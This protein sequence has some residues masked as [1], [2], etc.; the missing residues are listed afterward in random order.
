MATQII[1]CP[2]GLLQDIRSGFAVRQPSPDR[3]VITL[4]PLIRE[5]ECRVLMVAFN[6]RWLTWDRW[7]AHGEPVFVLLLTSD[8]APHE[9]FTPR[10]LPDHMVRSAVDALAE[11]AGS[12]LTGHAWMELVALLERAKT[13]P[14][15]LPLVEARRAPRSRFER[16][17]V[18]TAMHLQKRWSPLLL[19]LQADI[20][21][22]GTGLFRSNV[23]PLVESL[24]T[25]GRVADQLSLTPGD[26]PGL[27]RLAS[28]DPARYQALATEI[29]KARR[30]RSTNW[31]VAS[32]LC[33]YSAS[34]RERLSSFHVRELYRC[35][36][37]HPGTD[38]DAPLWRREDF[39]GCE[40]PVRVPAAGI[41]A[42]LSRFVAAFDRQL[43][44][45]ISPII[46][47][48]LAMF[49]LLRIQP[50][51]RRDRDAAL[52]LVY[53]LLR[54]AG[55]PPL[56][57]LLIIHERYWQ[58]AS[59]MVDA[60]D[61]DRPDDLA[62]VMI[63][64][65]RTALPLGIRMTNQLSLERHALSESLRSAGFDVYG[66]ERAVSVLLSKPLARVWISP[67]IAPPEE[68]ELFPHAGHLHEEGLIDIIEI[69]GRRWWSSPLARDLAAWRT[70]V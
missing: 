27:W 9:S 22:Y 48:A 7:P 65:V 54:E 55:L 59:A 51:G 43:L 25:E 58:L 5:S 1:H 47:S 3:P 60:L 36:F 29:E 10:P 4:E 69:N 2:L 24:S 45:G 30:M 39:K 64:V 56:P 26:R 46:M 61:R 49:H 18:E 14:N 42:A 15:G 35:G 20:A 13:E 33:P 19:P 28:D 44:A 41:E 38:Y 67:E 21:A 6:D 52:L 53:T 31:W 12:W 50:V 16:K 63:D 66:T 62:E 11:Q 34:P 8:L 57:V 37:A 40:F 68:A 70:L 23:G 17:L 32:A